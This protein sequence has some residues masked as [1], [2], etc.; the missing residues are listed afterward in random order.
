MMTELV[1]VVKGKGIF[2]GKYYMET[3]KNSMV[4]KENI[5]LASIYAITENKR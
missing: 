3:R 5:F 4:C 1:L 2:S